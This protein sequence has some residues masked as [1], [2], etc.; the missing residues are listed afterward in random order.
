MFKRRISSKIYTIFL[1]LMAVFLAFGFSSGENPL[2][3]KW[4]CDAE[5]TMK[6]MET[7][8]LSDMEKQFYLTYFKNISLK[9]TENTMELQMG[10]NLDKSSYEIV[11]KNSNGIK[12]Y[13][14]EDDKNDFFEMLDNDRFKKTLELES[15]GM[16]KEMEIFFDR[17]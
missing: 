8:H 16:K 13:Y 11:E 5:K 17:Q 2:I 14:P 6:N 4:K 10:G 1:L 15:K 12:V 3:G 9:V 7:S